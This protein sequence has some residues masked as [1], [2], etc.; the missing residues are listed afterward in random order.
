MGLVKN[1]LLFGWQNLSTLPLSFKLTSST[2]KEASSHTFELFSFGTKPTLPALSATDLA[3]ATTLNPSL[4]CL[5]DL[6]DFSLLASRFILFFEGFISSP[7][8]LFSSASF[9]WSWANFFDHRR[10]SFEHRPISSCLQRLSWHAAV[11]LSSSL[12]S[13]LSSSDFLVSRSFALG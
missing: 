4:N 9:C 8:S 2:V 11:F 1:L 10:S 13:S 12:R 5:F 7:A 6:S 3:L